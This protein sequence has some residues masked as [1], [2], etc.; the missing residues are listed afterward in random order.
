MGDAHDGLPG[1]EPSHLRNRV[2]DGAQLPTQP[3]IPFPLSSMT[4]LIHPGPRQLSHSRAVQSGPQ[5]HMSHKLHSAYILTMSDQRA[6]TP[7]K[8]VEALCHPMADAECALNIAL[9]VLKSQ[10]KTSA[11]VPQ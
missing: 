10:I 3:F 1:V 6:I 5:T 7:E 4:T 9:Y 2:W 8:A 11:P